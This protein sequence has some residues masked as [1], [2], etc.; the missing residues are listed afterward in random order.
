MLKWTLAAMFLLHILAAPVI[1]DWTRGGH[2]TQEN[3][4]RREAG[5]IRPSPKNPERVPK[6]IV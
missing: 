6:R 1:A 5:P 3:Q 2:L 4:P